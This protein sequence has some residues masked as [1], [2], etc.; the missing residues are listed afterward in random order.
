VKPL[1]SHLPPRS[2]NNWRLMTAH[3]LDCIIN[4]KTPFGERRGWGAGD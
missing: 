2:P 3:Y 4:D 1:G